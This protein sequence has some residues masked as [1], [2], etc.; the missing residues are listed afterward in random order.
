MK[1]KKEMNRKLI[2]ILLIS[3]LFYAFAVGLFGPIYAMFVS[4]IGGDIL[5][6]SGAWATFAIVN[7]AIVILFGKLSDK[8]FNKRYMVFFGFLIVALGT[9]GYLFVS[10]PIHLFFVQA[11]LGFGM[12]LVDPP[13]DALY[14]KAEDDGKEA[15]EWSFWE[16]GQLIVG[17]ISAIIGGLIATYFGF[18]TLFI[19]MFIFNCL[20]AAASL[21]LIK[22]K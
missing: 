7:G 10:A 22:E 8:K 12:A 20:A 9:L 5:D 1:I 21:M 3:G 2:R 14:G 17:G 16:G 15:S 4:R 19:T 11:I 6:A 13:W 18:T